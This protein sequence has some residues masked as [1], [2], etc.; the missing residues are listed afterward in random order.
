MNWAIVW[1]NL[2]RGEEEG[3]P[4]LVSVCSYAE[5]EGSFCGQVRVAKW[6]RFPPPPPPFHC[7]CVALI[8]SSLLLSRVGTYAHLQ[9]VHDDCWDGYAPKL[10]VYVAKPAA[11]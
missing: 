6:Y 10:V 4:S 7:I 9:T 5:G 2:P 8:A 3:E 11:V 1:G